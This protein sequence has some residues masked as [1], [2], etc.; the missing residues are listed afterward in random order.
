M[1]KNNQ[2]TK[3]NESE[4]E[5]RVNREVPEFLA[6]IWRNYDIEGNGLLDT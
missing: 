1:L 4:L 5:K 2:T 6:Q 3:E